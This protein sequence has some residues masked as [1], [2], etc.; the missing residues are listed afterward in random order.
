MIPKG[1]SIE[2]IEKHIDTLFRF[3]LYQKAKRIDG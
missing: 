1:D 3:S 2:L